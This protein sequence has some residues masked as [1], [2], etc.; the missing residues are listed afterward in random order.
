M[1]KNNNHDLDSSLG[2]C[3][4]LNAIKEKM[5]R[6]FFDFLQHEQ[7]YSESEK[8]WYIELIQ[9]TYFWYDLIINEPQGFD[10]KKQITEYLKKLQLHVSDQLDKRFIYFLAARK[11]VRF[12]PEK[13]PKYT[14]IGNKLVVYIRIGNKKRL[15]KIVREILDIETKKTITPPITICDRLITFHYTPDKKITMSIYDFLSIGNLDLG[16]STEIHY[17]G[18]TQNPSK[19]PINRVHRGF[20][21]MLYRTPTDEYDFFVYYNLFKVTSLGLNKHANMGFFF[22][23]AM[24]DEVNADA[25]GKIIETA[26]IKYF[27]TKPQE[28]NKTNETA[29]LENNLEKLIKQNKINS[30][31]I[32]L[33][34]ERHQEMFRF[35][36]R[37]IEP[38][39]FHSFTIRLG[40]QG[41]ELSKPPVLKFS[42]E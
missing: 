36:S 29:E 39:D 2:S 12:A 21:D 6:G 10:T 27:D 41:I 31:S 25:E 9:S 33:E 3:D 18:Y 16:M 13:K 11:K 34:M 32:H 15:Q 1:A 19:R 38:A 5:S 30:I 20:A 28:F 23:N 26:L 37:T 4:S 14:I 24:I 8:D 22:S 7:A 35:C 42:L 40:E 17:V